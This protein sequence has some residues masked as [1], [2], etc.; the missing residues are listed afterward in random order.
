MN[1]IFNSLF[2]SEPIDEKES[3][4]SNKQNKYRPNEIVENLFTLI[5]TIVNNSKKKPLI[6]VALNFFNN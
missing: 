2:N 4:R 1:I 5:Q 3:N 6:K